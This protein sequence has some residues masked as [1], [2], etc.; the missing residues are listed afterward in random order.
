MMDLL[1]ME[2]LM[3]G[4][5]IADR[6]ADGVVD[7]QAYNAVT[8]TVNEEVLMEAKEEVEKILEN[9]KKIKDE[10]N[11]A[12]LESEVNEALGV[13]K[14]KTESC[15]PQHECKLECGEEKMLEECVGKSTEEC[16]CKGA[17]MTKQKTPKMEAKESSTDKKVE[18]KKQPVTEAKAPVATPAVGV[19]T[20][21]KF[22]QAVAIKQS[23]FVNAN[24]E[25]QV[26]DTNDKGKI[27]KEAESA[28]KEKRKGVDKV[29]NQNLADK[30]NEVDV[31][32]PTAVAPVAK[33]ENAE[34][35]IGFVESIKTD[36]TAPMIEAVLKA[37]NV[38]Y[39]PVQAEAKV[40]AVEDK[41]EPE[42]KVE[43]AEDKKEP[44]A[45]VEATEEKKVPK[46]E[47][48]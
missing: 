21:E 41:K 32:K 24:T 19:D 4:A 38:I 3:E 15:D 43:A 45:K 13:E 37:F 16:N 17:E 7:E 26:S 33:T 48:K 2:K 20:P 11:L 14:P 46:K 27:D 34:K 42:A 12:K 5:K 23:D 31:L 18:A 10:P 40:E 30:Q 39:K 22:Q 28:M 36:D 8:K 47:E 1:N 25:H 9:G 35:F 44:E 6:I 29:R